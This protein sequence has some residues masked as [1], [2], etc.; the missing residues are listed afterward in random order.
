MQVKLTNQEITFILE[1]LSMFKDQLKEDGTFEI[2]NTTDFYKVWDLQDK[3][4]E[5]NK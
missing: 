2:P 5:L 1:G 3:L 4:T